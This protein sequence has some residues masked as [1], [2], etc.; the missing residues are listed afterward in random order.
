[1]AYTSAPEK[2]TYATERIPAAIGI[3]TRKNISS[4]VF[5][6]FNVDEGMLNLIPMKH[7]DERGQVQIVAEEKTGDPWTYCFYWN[8]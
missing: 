5:N 4:T 3:N 6:A 8:C 1:M 7:K 2:Q